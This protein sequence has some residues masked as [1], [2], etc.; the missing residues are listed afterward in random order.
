MSD[1]LVRISD[2]AGHEY[3]V[4]KSKFHELYEELGY[5]ITFLI[6]DSEGPNETLPPDVAVAPETTTEHVAPPPVVDAVPVDAPVVEAPVVDAAVSAEVVPEAAPDG[7]APVDVSPIAVAPS[8]PPV[9]TAP[10][11]EGEVAGGAADVP[12]A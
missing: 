9:E 7:S 11:V 3:Q 10:V 2:E 6:G 12:A 8:E 5:R 4:F 1:P